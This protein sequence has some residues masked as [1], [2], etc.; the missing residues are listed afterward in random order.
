GNSQSFSGEKPNNNGNEKKYEPPVIGYK[1]SFKTGINSPNKL[2]TLP[3]FRSKLQVLYWD[4]IKDFLEIE[5]EFVSIQAVTTRSAAKDDEENARVDDI[6]G[7]PIAVGTLEEVID[8]DHAIIST[9]VT[10]E[11]YVS[12]LSIVDRTQ[13]E[14]GC[15]V[16]LN[17]K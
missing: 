16:L 12:I 17:H 14:P 6:R 2:P 5:R 3:K 8:E 4:R 7:T 10:S 9:S 15:Q 1:H 11:H 13:L